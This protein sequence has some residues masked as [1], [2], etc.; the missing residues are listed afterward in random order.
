VLESWES[1]TIPVEVEVEPEP[2][3][4]E[5]AESPEEAPTRT[6]SR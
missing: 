4:P 3:E 2:A 6:L 5:P 1:G